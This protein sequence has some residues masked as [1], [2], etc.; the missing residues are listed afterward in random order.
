MDKLTLNDTIKWMTSDNFEDH[1]VA[2][3]VQVKI[4]LN[5][6]VD[7]LITNEIRKP[8]LLFLKHYMDLN[9]ADDD[10][11]FLLVCQLGALNNY[12]IV[13][14]KRIKSLGIDLKTYNI[15]DKQWR[16]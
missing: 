8:T 6:L 7:Y 3:Y 5:K 16:Y 10:N 1:L 12:S 11:D 4:R 9:D 13:L 2:E 15:D 14:L